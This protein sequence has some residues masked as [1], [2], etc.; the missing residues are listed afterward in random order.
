MRVTTGQPTRP[1]REPFIAV[2]AGL[3]KH[4]LGVIDDERRYEYP[5]EAEVNIA[6]A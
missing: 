2:H 3:P 1:D 6:T 4:Q 5:V